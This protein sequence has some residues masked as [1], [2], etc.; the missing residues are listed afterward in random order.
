MRSNFPFTIIDVKQ[1]VQLWT[2]LVQSI[3]GEAFKYNLY[4]SDPRPPILFCPCENNHR[5]VPWS[6]GGVTHKLSHTDLF[7]E[8]V[9]E[10]FAN[11]PY[12]STKWWMNSI[13][14]IKR[15]NSPLWIVSNNYDL[16]NQ[17]W[18]FYLKTTLQYNVPS[19]GERSA[20]G[21]GFSISWTQRVYSYD[22]CAHKL[23][24]RKNNFTTKG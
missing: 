20:L 3:V 16:P 4:N 8:A 14:I 11:C 9:D 1:H 2:E 19:I 13:I 5:S 21:S 17:L 24:K 6:N 22:I 12:Y 10:I 7:L 23:T 15:L 18:Q